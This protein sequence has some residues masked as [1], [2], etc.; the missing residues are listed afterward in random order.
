[1]RRK[2]FTFQDSQNGEFVHLNACVGEKSGIDNRNG[3]AWGFAISVK[4]ML[5]AA[6]VGQYFDVKDQDERD[7]EIDGLIYPIAFCARHHMELF[8]KRE[9]S[10]IS[11]IRGSDCVPPT[12]HNLDNLLRKFL[13]I[14]RMTDRFLFSKAEPLKQY[15]LDFA[16]IDATGQTFRYAYDK[17]NIEHLRQ[18][19]R[20]NLKYF[21]ERFYEMDELVTEFECAREAVTWEYAQ[22]TFTTKLSRTELSELTYAL[23][24]RNEWAGSSKFVEVRNKFREKYDL[25]SND[26]S[27]AIKLI[28]GHRGF[29]AKLGVEI[30]IKELK[31]DIFPKLYRIHSCAADITTVCQLEWAALYAIRE[32]GRENAYCEAYEVELQ[33]A[34][35][36]IKDGA[37]DCWHILRTLAIIDVRFMKGL[38]RLGQ[39]TL[40]A[41]YKENFQNL[42]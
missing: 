2:N 9:I 25:S 39:S 8:L 4:I 6:I 42:K 36:R 10:F 33:D 12:D 3:Y 34:I 27:R 17:N 41:G 20:I 21:A 40:L 15:I 19:G 35:D 5:S 24:K 7:P 32:V 26:F 38:Q 28:E 1:M 37:I 13:D 18:V 31:I 29:S 14:C 22:G 30:P 23:P 16:D 11:A